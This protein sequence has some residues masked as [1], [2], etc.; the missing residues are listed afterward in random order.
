MTASH[1]TEGRTPNRLAKETSP[2]LQQHQ[3]N[4]VDWHPWGPEALALAKKLDKPIF[5]SIGYSACHW[6]H[7]MERESFEDPATAAVMNE[8]FVNIKV[9]REERPDL[10]QIYMTAVQL[11]TMQGGW[12]MSVWLTPDLKP[13]YGGTYFPPTPRYGR[14][15]FSDLCN[16]LAKA[17]RERRDEIASV[18]Q[19]LVESIQETDRL[20]PA[21]DETGPDAS[22]VVNGA[23]AVLSQ[24]DRELGG[25]GRAP[26]FPHT[27]ELRLL[28]NVGAETGDGTM[29]GHALHSIESMIRGGIY[30]QL[31][32]GLHRY[33]TDQEW[34]V[35]HFEKML[36]DNALFARACLEA[37]QYSKRPIF[38]RA[39]RETLDYVLREMKAPEGLFYSTQ[40]ADSEGHE[41]KFFVWS[42]AEIESVLGPEAGAFCKTYGVSAG[43]NWE[44]ANILHL[45]AL[46]FSETEVADPGEADPAAAFVKERMQLWT[47]R[48]GRNKPGRD[49]KILAAWNGM[50]I[51]AMAAAGAALGEQRY[52]EAAKSAANEIVGS[53][54]TKKCRLLRTMHMGSDQPAKLNA[55]LEDY[56]WLAN[57]SISLY[58]ATFDP[59]W[60]QQAGVFVDQMID[61][62][63][64]DAAG[65]FFFT[66]KDHET[67]IAR[68]KDP[69]D[70]AT[71]S[72]NA[73]AA[74]A[75]AR[76]F[77][78]TGRTEIADRI[79]KLFALFQK[80]MTERPTGAA[81]ML[82]ALRFHLGPTF[83]VALIGDPDHPE[84]KAMLQRVHSRLLP[85]KVLAFRTNADPE[86]PLVPLLKDKPVGAEPAAYVCRNFTCTAPIRT[87]EELSLSLAVDEPS[88][89]G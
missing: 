86:E 52:I 82:L 18:S 28:L 74:M 58:E 32:G 48:E 76:L 53:M 25:I 80:T 83:A 72:G 12:P 50:M 89:N 61:L 38:E 37:W 20:T 4:P 81:Q 21:T 87:A 64:D 3:F 19:N 79:D 77:A 46:P 60:L 44:G 65:G 67:L 11:M 35:P 70:G 49:E 34:L 56:A 54:V 1:S 71:P 45:P 8:H 31:G 73:V 29:T 15:S 7:V 30:D 62:F 85:N 51:D 5:L 59:K 16:H 26:K 17:Y 23:K 27:V 75:M 69:H 33:S 9:D 40:D 47:K 43:G 68:S 10:D 39:L 6:C 13:F 84:A 88:R 66:G 24:V 78:L 42:K 41:G 57:G 2:Y 36:Y 14:P 63:W 22:L 55:Y